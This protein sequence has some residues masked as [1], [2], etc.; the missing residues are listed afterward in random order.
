MIMGVCDMSD[1]TYGRVRIGK[2]LADQGLI[3]IHKRIGRLVR[4][5][6]RGDNSG[7]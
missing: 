3:V 6:K 4:F 2:E 7:R 5:V 1:S